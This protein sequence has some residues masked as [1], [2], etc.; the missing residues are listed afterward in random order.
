[1]LSAKGEKVGSLSAKSELRKHYSAK[2]RELSNVELSEYSRKICGFIRT[3]DVYKQAECVAGFS[4]LGAEPDLS[5]LFPEKRFFLPRYDAEKGAY[6]MVEI[7]DWESDLTTGHYNITEPRREIEAAGKAWCDANLLYLIPAVACDRRG[8]RLGRGGGFYDR[9][10]EN[11]Q[12]PKVGVIFS[13]Q[14]AEQ[15]PCGEPHDVRLDIVVTEN[16]V[17]ECKSVRQ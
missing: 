11:S 15:L 5:S 9:L 4:A 10:L 3:L 12:L 1:M 8:V 17:L 7:R 13:C 16:E 2:R 14:L 6:S